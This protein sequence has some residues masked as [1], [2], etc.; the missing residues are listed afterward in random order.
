M[1]HR[2]AYAG[3]IAIA[4]AALLL[5]FVAI[6]N[7]WDNVTYFVAL[8]GKDRSRQADQAPNH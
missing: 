2:S 7:A 3:L 5:I 6:H 4:A 1:I 8:A